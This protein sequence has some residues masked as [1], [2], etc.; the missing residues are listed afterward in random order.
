MPPVD[1]TAGIHLR[2]D[3]HYSLVPLLTD[4]DT[5]RD[6][7]YTKEMARIVAGL[8]DLVGEPIVAPTASRY[9]LAKADESEAV[10]F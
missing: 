3:G 8:R 6:F 5:Y 10:P 1:F 9:V 7:L 4:E 2:P